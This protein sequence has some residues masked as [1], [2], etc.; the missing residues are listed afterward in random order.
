M[1][2]SVSKRRVV[3]HRD[4]QIIRQRSAEAAGG[5]DGRV[6]VWNDARGLFIN[7]SGSGANITGIS[8][9]H[10]VEHISLCAAPVSAL[11]SEVDDAIVDE[12]D[13]TVVWERRKLFSDPLTILMTFSK[14]HLRP[15]EIVKRDWRTG[16]IASRHVVEDYRQNAGEAWF[17][18]RIAR[19]DYHR[20]TEPRRKTT[21]EL[22]ELR[23][24]DAADFS[25]LPPVIAEG[26]EVVDERCGPDNRCVYTYREKLGLPTDAQVQAMVSKQRRRGLG[27]R[28]FQTMRGGWA[29]RPA[30]R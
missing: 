10:K 14:T 19:D 22:V 9:W 27:G 7:S 30:S 8:P 23:L 13:E 3:Y 18:R 12:T 20:Q 17:P 4:G 28:L 16:Q 5:R 1:N 25:T 11:Y 24:N 26:A 6:F 29:Q 21:H 2:G 15:V